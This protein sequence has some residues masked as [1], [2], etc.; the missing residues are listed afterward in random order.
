MATVNGEQGN[1]DALRQRKNR[2]EIY[3]NVEITLEQGYGTSH[4][5]DIPIRL[6]GGNSHS[7]SI[8]DTRQNDEF[9]PVAGCQADDRQRQD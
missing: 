5:G 8:E 4:S 9:L 7:F 6:G 1:S 2:R 3:T